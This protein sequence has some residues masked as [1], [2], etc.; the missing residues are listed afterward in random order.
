MNA[1]IRNLPIGVKVALAPAVAIVCLLL[2]ALVA[3]LTNRATSDAVTTL[4]SETLPDLARYAELKLRLARLDALVMR[5]L[6]F[7]GAG[8]KAKRIKAIDEQ[9][10]T[11]LTALSA[12]LTKLKGEASGEEQ[13]LLAEGEK[14]LLQFAKHAAEAID[15]KSGGLSQS[16]MVM[17]SSEVEFA[18]LSKALDKLAS[19]ANQRATQRADDASQAMARSGVIAL[20]LLLAAV[21]VSAAAT[22]WCVRLITRPLADAV[23]IATEVAT[24]NLQVQVRPGGRDATGQVLGALGTVTAKLNTMVS[25]ITRAADQ[26]NSASSEIASGNRDLS[27]HTE[28]TASSLQQTASIVEQLTAQMQA[29]SAGASKAKELASEAAG[30]AREGGE[31]VQ[32]VVATMTQISD[33]SLR[34]RDIIGVIDGIAFQTN[35]LSLNAAVEAARAGEQGRGFAVVA[36][37]VRALAS[38]SSDAAKEIRSLISASVEQTQA[39][40]DRVQAAGAIMT[41]IVAQVEQVSGMVAE[42]A[43]ANNEQA[44][45]VSG[46]NEAVGQMDHGTQQN[47]ALVEQASAATEALRQ[48]A[49][50][51]MH[52]LSVF[53][54]A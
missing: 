25:D 1:F 19:L 43:R 17:T 21:A 14:W 32:G 10:A 3:Q 44:R 34:I 16:A 50:G 35:I 11:E 23:R 27:S 4:H 47:A 30:V 37:E 42:L 48:Q 12:Y 40:A 36:Q 6:A 41:R 51:L 46:V 29:N 26:I 33:Q 22:W 24:G 9:I 15:M 45:G 8:M 53:K 54:T 5:S 20:G 38:R 7:E 28:Q 18:N 31:L 49:E 2:V 39:G 13:A 52:A